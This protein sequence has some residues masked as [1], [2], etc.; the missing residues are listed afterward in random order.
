MITN[1][2]EAA[3]V[4]NDGRWDECGEWCLAID[5]G[6]RD[7]NR[8]KT[9]IAKRTAAVALELGKGIGQSLDDARIIT[10]VRNQS[11]FLRMMA[12]AP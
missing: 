7:I 5:P 12:G 11:R 2:E 3:R 4:F 8:L 10:A 1:A 9:R 6:E